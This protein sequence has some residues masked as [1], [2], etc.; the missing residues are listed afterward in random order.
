M[1]PDL[2]TSLTNELGDMGMY[3]AGGRSQ[4]D[5]ANEAK[6]W[7]PHHATLVGRAKLICLQVWQSQLRLLRGGRPRLPPRTLCIAR[8]RLA[9][10]AIAVGAI[11]CVLYVKISGRPLPL[12]RFAYV[13][14][15]ITNQYDKFYDER[16][17]TRHTL[18]CP[19]PRLPYMILTFVTTDL[20]KVGIRTRLRK[21]YDEYEQKHPDT[22]A[23]IVN[24]YEFAD[25]EV[26]PK[27][28][29]F[30]KHC[31]ARVALEKNCAD[32]VLVLDA[33]AV[34]VN[35][36][37]H[38]SEWM[39]AVDS[40]Q[41]EDGGNGRDLYFNRRPN[42]EVCACGYIARNT[43][44]AKNFLLRWSMG[45]DSM[46]CSTMGYD[47][48]T[49]SEML[50]EHFFRN[51]PD[52]GKARTEKFKKIRGTVFG[53]YQYAVDFNNIFMQE[54]AYYFNDDERICIFNENEGFLQEKS[55]L[56]TPPDRYIEHHHWSD[57]CLI[58]LGCD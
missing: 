36:D 29:I 55:A 32:T 6:R 14:N 56:E 54:T 53:I 18:E 9:L 49:L 1:P 31:I 40:T 5:G 27:T 17:V 52:G 57:P 46:P 39:D 11:F 4:F 2:Q 24:P 21:V 10:S 35:L 19:S 37:L 58:G 23:W 33:D 34:P 7:K 50:I 26:G 28:A 47:Q 25:C 16:S 13:S 41:G 15:P 30:K 42:N 45:F 22:R 12:C 38:F 43:E 3:T 44:F 8:L 51:L 48:G 20:E